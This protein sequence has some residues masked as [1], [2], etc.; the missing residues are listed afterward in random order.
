MASANEITQNV[1]DLKAI[2]NI[3]DLGQ[4][5]VEQLLERCNS[6]IAG[7]AQFFP[8]RRNIIRRASLLMRV[9]AQQKKLQ[10]RLNSVQHAAMDTSDN[11]PLDE[12]IGGEIADNGE[13]EEEVDEASAE[14]SNGEEEEKENN[15]VAGENSNGEEE[16]NEGSANLVRNRVSNDN[17]VRNRV[18]N[19]NLVW[20][21]V[22]RMFRSAIRM[23]EIV[24]NTHVDVGV[25]VN[26]CFPI[27]KIKVEEIVVKQPIKCYCVL[28]L[29][30]KSPRIGD[31]KLIIKWLHTNAMVIFETTNLSEWYDE[32]VKAYIDRRIDSFCE[33]GSGWTV[34]RIIKLTVVMLNY[35]PFKG[36]SFIPLP[37]QI[38]NRRATVNVKNKDNKCFVWS[39]L[40]ALCKAQTNRNRVQNYLP[41]VNELNFGDLEFP[42]KVCD[43]DKFEKLNPT[44][45]INL[46]KLRLINGEYIVNPC[47]Q[48]KKDYMHDKN[49][50]LINLLYLQNYYK[51]EGMDDVETAKLNYLED[52]LVAHAEE[53]QAHYVLITCLETLLNS[54]ISKN[55]HKLNLC[56]GCYCRFKSKEKLEEHIPYC[57]KMNGFT[58]R[59]PPT[60]PGSPSLRYPRRRRS[61]SSTPNALTDA[62]HA[63]TID[64]NGP[65]MQRPA[66][67]AHQ[68]PPAGA[69]NDAAEEYISDTL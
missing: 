56:E 1:A 13:E 14:I 25:F 8:R 64:S 63:E 39:I 26:D 6:I 27:F 31:E 58:R 10:N 68:H 40:A 5:E 48:S 16:N 9:Q 61:P 44:I 57:R 17:L 36:G 32:H 35:E 47:R 22:E 55:G 15:E 62:A 53:I 34:N 38:S 50:K 18:S 59:Q 42:I 2:R 11:E 20:R 54:Q 41:Y 46:H 51:D 33:N 30:F 29:E 69:T 37:Q 23:G 45:A 3:D 52:P 24:N 67:A 66:P 4:E 12:R 7:I 21:D 28:E 43:I 19:D 49:V 60:P 65:A